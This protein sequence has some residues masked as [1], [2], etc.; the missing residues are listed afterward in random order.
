MFQIKIAP[1]LLSADFANLWKEVEDITDAW[2]DYLHIDVM[3][4]HF[5]GNMTPFSS[6]MVQALKKY[7]SQVFDVHLMISNPEKY[8]KDFAKAGAGIITVHQEAT[9]HIDALLGE[10]KGLWVKSWVSLNPGTPPEF[11]KE[12]IHKVD[13][14]LV[15][16]V[17][18][19]FGGQSFIDKTEKITYIRWLIDQSGRDI[20]LQVDGGINAETAKKCTDAGAD[21]LVAGSYVFQWWANQ[22]ARNIE[23][24]RVK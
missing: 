21:V 20:D 3:D 8:I 13:L 1:S 17:N 14:I 11:I 23:N 4:G 15:M 2:A 16:T 6:S 18:P 7:S 9:N 19:W 24:L 10:I 22:Y 5:V 12:I